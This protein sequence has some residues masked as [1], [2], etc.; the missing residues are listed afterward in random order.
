[1]PRKK[2]TLTG[3]SAVIYARYSSTAQN[4]ASIEQQVDK[5]REYAKGKGLTIL[6][7]Y[8]DRAMSGRSDKRP[9]F[10]RMMKDAVA[11]KFN[12]VI[13]WKSSRMGR[14]MLE[15]MQNDATLQNCGVRCMYVE[16]DF[17]DSAAGRL[18]L[19]MMMSVNQF[20]SENMAE[21]IFRG[22][23]DNA[24][25]CKVNGSIPFGYQ[26]GKDGKYAINEEDAAIVREIF[27]RIANGEIKATIASDLNARGLKT[28][29]GGPWGKNSFNS[30]L[31]NERYTGVYIYGDTRIEGGVPAIISKDT[32]TRARERNERMSAAV[33]SRR[34]R[35]NVDY[36][37]TGK[38]FCGHCRKA[39]V[40][41]CGTGKLGTMYYYYRCNTQAVEHTCTKKPVRK[42][43]IE[44]LI[45]AAIREI[46]L[47]DETIQ[48]LADQF[49][50]AKA[51]LEGE[52]DLSLLEDKLREN[53][54]ALGN[55]MKAIEA[56]VITESTTNR[57]RELEAEKRDL[58]DQIEHERSMIPQFSRDEV[59]WYL[60]GFRLGDIEDKRTQK[61]LI[62]QFLRAAYLYDD[63]LHLIFDYMEDGDGLDVDLPEDEINSS[64]SS[65]ENGV[66]I[67]DD[68]VYQTILIRT[69]ILRIR[70]RV[71]LLSF[72]FIEL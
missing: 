41:T 20:H 44:S 36:I 1:M 14:N 35:D 68:M 12:C 72:H 42:E 17:D 33:K 53:K 70:G 15:A 26:R 62:D 61:K 45:A 19:R 46:V 50:L 59:V 4:D 5:C 9:D 22:L 30:I 28:K 13:A 60:E 6:E 55:M 21:D 11:G 67:M 66:L 40:G 32:Y 52:S 23:M 18:A 58:T 27:N 54:V 3:T 47:Q 51:K 24:K 2:K 63:H 7:V 16:E 48:W 56:G 39:M 29:T 64:C 71:F 37:L 8:A 69:P 31:H 65:D 49:V 43:K 34:R 25:Q 57:L 10:Q 38:L